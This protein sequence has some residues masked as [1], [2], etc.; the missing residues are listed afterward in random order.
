MADIISN[1][2]ATV[3]IQHSKG[4][5]ENMQDNP[6]YDD[7]VEEIYKYLHKKAEY[8]LN[9]GINNLILDV[10]IGFGK[11]KQ[12]CYKI[13]NRIEEFF[14]LGYPIMVGVSRK[15]MLGVSMEDNNLKDILTLAVSYPLMQKGVD[16]L[17]V[18]NVKLHKQL[19]NQAM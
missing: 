3:I 13:L 9:K 10:G 17:R 18:H 5:P 8:A 6:Y 12:D 4:T 16:F 19:L 11:T 15:S 7:V 14:S 2:N 1:S